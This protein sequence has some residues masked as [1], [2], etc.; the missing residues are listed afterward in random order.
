[1]IADKHN[2][3]EERKTFQLM[4][5]YL[6]SLGVWQET[7]KKAFYSRV[8]TWLERVFAMI[9]SPVVIAV[10]PGHQANLNCCDFMH[11]IVGGLKSYK[12]C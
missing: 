4:L 6:K 9:D 5:V 10:A 3:V 12:D 7:R 1:M 8:L 2:L 11:E